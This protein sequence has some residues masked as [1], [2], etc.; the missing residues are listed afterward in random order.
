MRRSTIAATEFVA[1]EGNE[2]AAMTESVEVLE[3]SHETRL[4]QDDECRD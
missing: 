1:I 2:S 4:S 3:Y